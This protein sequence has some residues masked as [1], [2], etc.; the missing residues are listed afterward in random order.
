MVAAK[1]PGLAVVVLVLAGSLGC[2]DGIWPAAPTAEGATGRTSRVNMVNGYD[3]GLATARATGKPV[4]LIFTARW[5]PY[6]REV[7]QGLRASPLADHFVCVRVDADREPTVA[8][9]FRVTGYPTV[10]FLS[11][12]GVPLNRVVGAKGADVMLREMRA[13]LSAVARRQGTIR[14]L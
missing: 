6:C 8:E 3:P 9:S 13:A 5:V 10:V 14:R 2:S 11:P 12:D 4:L 7:E 1:F